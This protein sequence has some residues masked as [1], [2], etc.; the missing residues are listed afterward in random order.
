MKRALLTLFTF[1]C[2]L[3]TIYSGYLLFAQEIS[4]L[5]GSVLL[6]AGILLSIWVFTLWQKPKYK[7]KPS[8]VIIVA[9]LILLFAGS[10]GAYAGYEPLAEAKDSV[11]N[12]FKEANR[13]I[14]VADR[15]NYFIP[16]ASFIGNWKQGYLFTVKEWE[17][18][19]SKDI[20]FNIDKT[21]W[22][23]NAGYNRTS[24]I[25]VRFN[26]EVLKEVPELPGVNVGYMA[27]ITRDGISAVT[28]EEKGKFTIHVDASGC[29]WWARVGTE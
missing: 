19:D 26:I 7:L 20:S 22:V 17:G 13:D 27:H 2:L 14:K 5:T 15:D 11:S 29:E 8:V 23:L 12:V 9:V 6:A 4:A 1:I 10:T 24:Q 3:S 21:P 28:I 25:S 16:P 18:K